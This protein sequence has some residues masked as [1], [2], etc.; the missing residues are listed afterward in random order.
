MILQVV[1]ISN[2]LKLNLNNLFKEIN[3][4]KYITIF[5]G[6]EVLKIYG[7]SEE[8]VLNEKNSFEIVYKDK[9]TDKIERT[10]VDY[11][12]IKNYLDS[13]RLVVII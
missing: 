7:A 1:E 4:K 8:D 13:Y 6:Q 11:Q 3:E 12:T 5:D 9:I 10:L 2:S